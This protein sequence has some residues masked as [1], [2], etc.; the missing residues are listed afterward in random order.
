[1]TLRRFVLGFAVLSVSLLFSPLES[2][3][4]VLTNHN[5]REVNR[6][7]KHQSVLL[8]VDRPS[9]RLDSRARSKRKSNSLV[10]LSP[11]P[12][13]CANLQDLDGFGGC[14][15]NC[16]RAWGVNYGSGTTCGAI[17]AIAA[18]GNPV[19]IGVCA[20][21]IGV[22]EWIVAGCAMKCSWD[23]SFVPIVEGPVSKS[24]PRPREL[25]SSDQA[26][27]RVRSRL[28]GS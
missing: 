17:C 24:L 28:H 11:K 18:T 10:H 22:A 26:R 19:A 15:G 5:S 3:A 20:A 8:R 14:F 16:L 2:K 7:S 23:S 6:S 4:K 12:N 9:T 25:R 13:A 27:L 21:C 1:M